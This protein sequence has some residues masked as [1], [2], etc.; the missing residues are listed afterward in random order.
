MKKLLLLLTLALL[1]GGCVV[2]PDYYGGYGYYGYNTGYYPYP[3]AYPYP[4]VYGPSVD[5]Y[6]GG[7][8][9]GRGFHHGGWRR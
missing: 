7:G 1:L 6:F 3:Y 8:H 4:Y 5:L 9:G 2:Y